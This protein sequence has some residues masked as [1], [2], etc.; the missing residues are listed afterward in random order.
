MI[1]NPDWNGDASGSLADVRLLI[2]DIDGVMT[3]GGL[4]YGE[5]GEFVK[6][7]DVQDGLGV[8]LLQHF[9]IEVAVISAKDSAPLRKRL[10][11]LGISIGSL[12]KDT[13]LTAFQALIADRGL[14]VSQVAYVGDDM[15]DIPVM[16]AVAHPITVA[17]GHFVT[18]SHAR[19]VT[20]KKGGNGAI[21]EVADA[22]MSASQDIHAAYQN[23]LDERCS[24]N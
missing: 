4:Y 24:S 11:D 7:F 21:R 15:L 13:K 19:W 17:N 16:Q 9:G 6:R 14:D 22:I 18:A 10:S 20:E 5:S 3:D 8:R 1:T 2:C 23:F 12:G